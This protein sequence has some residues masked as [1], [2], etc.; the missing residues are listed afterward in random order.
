VARGLV[1]SLWL[2]LLLPALAMVGHLGLGW[3]INWRSWTLA[4]LLVNLGS[5]AWSLRP[6]GLAKMVR[7]LDQRLGLRARLLTAWEVDRD[8]KSPA[9]QDNPVVQR[10]F[11][12]AV[13][14]AIGLRN[15]VRPW[16]LSFWLEVE[17]L[18]ALLVLLIGLLTLDA[19]NPATP[20]VAPV[21][22]PAVWQEP[23]A[24][25][26]LPPDA[27]LFPPPFAPQTPQQAARET[28]SA[29]SL[30]ALADALRD[31]AATRAIAEALDRGDLPGAAQALRR[32][33]DQLDELSPQARQELAEALRE[34]AEA[35]G[36]GAPGLSEPL[37]AGAEA[38]ENDDLDAASEALEDLAEALEQAGESPPQVAQT[39]P[40]DD[41]EAGDAGSSETGEPQ[42]GQTD[43]QSDAPGGGSGAGEGEGDEQ[44][45]EEERLAVEGQPLELE[46]ETES[47]TRVPQ[48]AEPGAEPGEGRASQSPFARQPFNAALGDLGPDPLT[49]PWEKRDVIRRYFTP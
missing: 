37:Q 6:I 47:E 28:P 21:D 8:P 30:Q 20:N 15:R 2:A 40:G 24:D 11:G 25:E 12:E 3:Q 45:T 49:Y 22:L 7:R 46:S 4:A 39:Q 36:D 16:N 14:I 9:H 5:L 42:T 48:P 41:A 43:E 32:L 1:R 35:I 33:A 34:A 31:P 18:L 38:L 19:L 10:L 23:A 26:V 17:T 13:K 44:P 29:E 27:E